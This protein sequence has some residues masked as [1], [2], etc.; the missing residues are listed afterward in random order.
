M[1][2][3]EDRGRSGLYV[4]LSTI[5][6]KSPQAR[7]VIRYLASS[8]MGPHRFGLVHRPP[9]PASAHLRAAVLGSNNRPAHTHSADEI[10]NPSAGRSATAR[11]LRARCAT[12]DAVRDR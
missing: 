8:D 10:D 3:S 2:W 1:V 6:T 4:P 7:T 9:A 11:R 12:R 5:A